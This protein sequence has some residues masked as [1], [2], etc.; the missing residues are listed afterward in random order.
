MSALIMLWATTLGGGCFSFRECLWLNAIPRFAQSLS[1]PRIALGIEY[2]GAGFCGWQTQPS[3]GAVQDAVDAALSSIAAEPI[4]SH[5]AGRTDAGVH[6][7]GQVIHFDTQARRPLS[8]WV[9]GVNGRLPRTVAVQWAQEVPE[10]FHARSSARGR[11]YLYLLVNR[12]ERPGLNHHRVGWHHRPLDLDRMHAAVGHLRGI[13]DFTSFRAAECQARSPVKD[14]RVAD[15]TRQGDLIAFRFAADAF[16]HHMVRNIVGCLVLVGKGGR[17][18]E[19]MLEVLQAR[20]RRLAAP[21]FD[22]AGLYLHAV[23]Y[24]GQWGLP[25]AGANFPPEPVLP[26]LPV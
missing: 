9:R 5:C 21:T 11:A 22:A 24:D 26:A 15:M 23:Q 13:H 14:L 19:W 17:P 18:P 12:R 1:M 2:D 6:A 3:G 25:G 4:S 8:A 16:L 10:A 20:D 7:L